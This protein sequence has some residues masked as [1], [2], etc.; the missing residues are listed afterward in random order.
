MLKGTACCFSDR[1]RQVPFVSC[2]LQE[3]SKLDLDFQLGGPSPGRAQWFRCDRLASAF[4]A[5]GIP[6]CHASHQVVKKGAGD[7]SFQV[8]CICNPMDHL[9]LM[10]AGSSHARARRAAPTAVPPKARCV[11]WRDTRH[12]CPAIVTMQSPPPP[13]PTRYS[14]YAAV[15]SL[16]A[17][18]LPIE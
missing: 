6:A 16:D 11:C 2:G 1:R 12:V 14:L 13:I 4:I 18:S 10:P 8:T 3:M 9:L 7:R 5:R 15:G 17:H